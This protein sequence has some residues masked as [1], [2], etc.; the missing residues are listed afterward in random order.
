M[1]GKPEA[2]PVAAVRKEQTEPRN[3]MGSRD[4]L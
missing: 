1:D 4:S 2:A 3:V